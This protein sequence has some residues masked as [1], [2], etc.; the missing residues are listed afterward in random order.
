MRTKCDLLTPEDKGAPPPQ[1]RVLFR[2]LCARR[3][4]PAG[5]S[6]QGTP[7]AAQTLVPWAVKSR[8]GERRAEAKQAD[9]ARPDVPLACLLPH[10]L[11]P[12]LVYN[13]QEEERELVRGEL[14]GK[15]G[16]GKCRAKR[17]STGVINSVHPAPRGGAARGFET[18][19]YV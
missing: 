7:L 16:Q 1:A 18:V 8:G 2:L 3:S 12:L 10:L 17:E 11:G 15:P 5:S 19:G 13:N 6:V 4:P 14:D 9:A